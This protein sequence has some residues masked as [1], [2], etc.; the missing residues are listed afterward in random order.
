MSSKIQNVKSPVVYQFLPLP[1]LTRESL[2]LKFFDQW[3]F[4]AEYYESLKVIGLVVF[5][6]VI[7]PSHSVVGLES[8][9]FSRSG[10]F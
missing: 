10:F 4:F 1:S 7:N 9:D 3:K 8:E 5:S 6:L 2:L